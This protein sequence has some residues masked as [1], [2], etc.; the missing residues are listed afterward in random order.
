[1]IEQAKKLESLLKQL[2]KEEKNRATLNEKALNMNVY[3]A[4]PRRM[5]TVRGNL[6]ESC[7]H[8]ERLKLQIARAFKGSQFDIEI[9]ERTS[10]TSG[11]H[12]YKI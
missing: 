2:Q 11:S 5:A 3:N 1:M 7:R 8:I 10:N 9:D 12:E 4:T 6:I